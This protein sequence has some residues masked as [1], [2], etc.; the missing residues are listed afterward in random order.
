MLVFRGFSQELGTSELIVY[1][2]MLTADSSPPPHLECDC[3]QS[4]LPTISTTYHQ[5]PNFT[6]LWS[7][8]SASALTIFLS[9]FLPYNHLPCRILSFP[10]VWTRQRIRHH[11]ARSWTTTCWK[12]AARPARTNF[13]GAKKFVEIWVRSP[14][15]PSLQRF[16]TDPIFFFIQEQLRA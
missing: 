3:P 11:T 13:P 10:L 8:K 2:L 12:S 4:P 7:I 5:S 15:H 14:S 16:P 6:C 9:L 1:V